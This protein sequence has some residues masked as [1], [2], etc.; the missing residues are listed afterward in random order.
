VNRDERESR[1]YNG[2]E[3]VNAHLSRCAVSSPEQIKP[4]I[5]DRTF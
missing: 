1:C 2:T 3:R 4:P 5:R